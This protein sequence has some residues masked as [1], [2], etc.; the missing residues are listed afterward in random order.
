MANLHGR[1]KIVSA[2]NG[3]VLDVQGAREDHTLIHHSPDGTLLNQVWFLNFRDSGV[4]VAS[5][6]SGLLLAAPFAGPNA[7]I[8]QQHP[9]TLTGKLLWRVIPTGFGGLVKIVNV[10]SQQG[11]SVSSLSPGREPGPSGSY[12]LYLTGE[13]NLEIVWQ[14]IVLG[15]GST[16]GSAR[17][18]LM[19]ALDGLNPITGL[20]LDV[21]GGSK[22]DGL[23]VQL[24]QDNGTDD[25]KWQLDEDPNRQGVVLIRS[26]TSGKVLDVPGASQASGAPIQQYTENRTPNQEWWLVPAVPGSGLVSI[27]SVESRKVLTLSQDAS[28]APLVQSD[29]TGEPNQH[30][31]LVQV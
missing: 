9:S 11:M 26:V 4:E 25:Q 1:Y 5:A 10:D 22:Q 6:A 21:P 16:P 7:T 19:A 18:K 12:P 17:V 27:V 2:L 13:N 8:V 28:Q 14:V 29:R 15:P 3:E 31:L 23:Q 20:L 30:W 24:H